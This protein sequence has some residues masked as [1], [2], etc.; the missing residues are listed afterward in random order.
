MVNLKGNPKLVGEIDP[1][2]YIMVHKDTIYSV[3]EDSHALTLCSEILDKVGTF[4]AGVGATTIFMPDFSKLSSLIM[5]V[6][7]VV[8]AGVCLYLKHIKNKKIN[9]ILGSKLNDSH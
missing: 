9:T 1:R 4:V 6:C 2:D 5:I 3:I 7:G 8:L